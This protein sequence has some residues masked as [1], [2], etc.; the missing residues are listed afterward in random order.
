MAGTRVTVTHKPSGISASADVHRNFSQNKQ[1]ALK[2]LRNRLHAEAVGF[3]LDEIGMVRSVDKE[4]DRVRHGTK[5]PS[6]GGGAQLL[7]DLEVSQYVFEN[8]RKCR[9]ANGVSK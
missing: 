3:R 6:T 8:I 2:L 4:R 7:E 9:K 1:E 5:S